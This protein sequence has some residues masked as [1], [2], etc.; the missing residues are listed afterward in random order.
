METVLVLNAN[1]E[2]LNVCDMRRAVCLMFLEKASLVMNGRGEIRTIDQSFPRP[3]IIRL[4][5][6]ITRPRPQ[7]KLNRKEIFRRDRFTCQYCGKLVRNLTIDHV[8][9]RHQGGQQKWENV[10]TA[11]PTCNHKKGGRALS[12]TGMHLQ[13]TP[14]IPPSSAFYIYKNYLN[15]NEEWEPFLKG[16]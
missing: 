1:F 6:M 2:P 11:C 5:R 12:E 8:V 13:K 10:V 4:E 14:E 7:V 16:W 3:S 9:P 15:E